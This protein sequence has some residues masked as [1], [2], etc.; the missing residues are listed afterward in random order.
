MS[1]LFTSG[2][3]SRTL[4]QQGNMAYAKHL[5]YF[6]ESADITVRESMLFLRRFL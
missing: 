6:I 3:M 1:S 4:G 2:E 5:G